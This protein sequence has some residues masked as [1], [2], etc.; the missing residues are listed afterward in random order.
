MYIASISHTFAHTNEEAL[1][2]HSQGVDSPMVCLQLCCDCL[3]VL[4]DLPHIHLLVNGSIHV[5]LQEDRQTHKCQ[6][7]RLTQ[8]II[9]CNKWHCTWN[10]TWHCT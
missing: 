10:C 2:G 9:F 5:A 7:G 3:K 1:A 4:F 8:H 6:V